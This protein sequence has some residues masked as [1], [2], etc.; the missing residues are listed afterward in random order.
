MQTLVNQQ[1]WSVYQKLYSD[2]GMDHM[3]PNENFVRLERWYFGGKKGSRVFDHGFGSGENLIHLARKGYKVD[4]VEIAQ[5]AV[6]L[7]QKKV[8]ARIAELKKNISLKLLSPSSEKLPYADNTFE[9]AVSLGV[10]CFSPSEAAITHSLNELHRIMKPNAKLILSTPGPKNIFYEKGKR[11]TPNVCCY[12]GREGHYRKKVKWLFY[13]FKDQNH[14]KK[15]F[16]SKFKIDDI[17]W[18]DNHYCNVHG[19]HWVVLARKR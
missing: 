3:Y 9:H 4:G 2:T 14:I 17:G 12:E 19:F 6:K 1:N 15:M 18:F 8:D 11:V 13:I 16:N 10:V 5:G 7:V